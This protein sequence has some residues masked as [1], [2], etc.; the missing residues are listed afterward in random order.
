MHHYAHWINLLKPLN[1]DV[2]SKLPEKQKAGFIDLSVTYLEPADA[3]ST[4]LLG[5]AK[6]NRRS[7]I[8]FLPIE[9]QPCHLLN[10]R[11]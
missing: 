5:A 9:R 1:K 7:D 6:G 11:K 8:Y 10:L 4:T 3:I 2:F